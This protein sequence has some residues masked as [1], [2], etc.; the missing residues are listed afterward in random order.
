MLDAVRVVF[1]DEPS[2]RLLIVGEGAERARLE[3]HAR[4]LGLLEMVTFTGYR[5]DARDVLRA[6]DAYVNSSIHE[7]VSLTLL[8]AMAAGLPV[9]AT[10]VGGT[11][12]VIT[13]RD[14]GLLVEPRSSGELAAAIRSLLQAPDRRLAL[15]N[16]ARARVERDFSL[17]A[18]T[19]QYLSA[20]RRAKA[21]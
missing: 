5:S 1:A 10:R 8:E 21:S 9:V 6:L 7:G 12:E 18:M 2:L 20:Y 3:R 11:P 14:T 16:A 13:D 19:G 15:G 4:E 17:D